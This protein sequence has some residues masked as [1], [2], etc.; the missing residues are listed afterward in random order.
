MYTTYTTYTRIGVCG[1]FVRPSICN[2]I[3]DTVGSSSVHCGI[4]I[5]VAPCPFVLCLVLHQFVS[6]R[7]LMTLKSSAERLVCAQL[8][9]RSILFLS[10]ISNRRHGPNP[11]AMRRPRSGS[12]LFSFPLAAE[13]VSLPSH[14]V[15][16]NCLA[17]I[18]KKLVTAGCFVDDGRLRYGMFKACMALFYLCRDDKRVLSLAEWQSCVSRRE[19]ENGLRKANAH[20]AISAVTLHSVKHHACIV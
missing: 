5:T 4:H 8:G 2:T 9:R 1:S 15:E 20:N 10:A 3:R 11:N 19:S 6:F 17:G 16:E 18:G 13:L 14:R 7:D 12:F